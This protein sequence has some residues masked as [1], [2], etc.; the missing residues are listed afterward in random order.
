ML[1]LVTKCYTKV[2]CGCCDFY[3]F[4]FVTHLS[5]FLLDF[6][7]ETKPGFVLMCLVVCF[8]VLFLLSNRFVFVISG[9]FDLS[10]PQ[11]TRTP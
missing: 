2:S 4:Y 3:G 11:S 7:R 9:I 5:V 10:A 6:T 1:L 8:C